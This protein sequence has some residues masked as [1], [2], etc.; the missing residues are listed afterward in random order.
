METCLNWVGDR[1]FISTDDRGLINRCLAGIKKNPDDCKI[2]ALPEENDGCLYFSCPVD[3][4]KRAI[5]NMFPP[6]REPMSAEQ[7]AATA[8]RLAAGKARKEGNRDG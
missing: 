3:F 2:I 8:A 5:R 1:A 6:K 7:R 4:G